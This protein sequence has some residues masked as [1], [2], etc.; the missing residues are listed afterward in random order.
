MEETRTGLRKEA[1]P[2]IETGRSEDATETAL[3]Q[4]FRRTD[5]S[6]WVAGPRRRARQDGGGV[7]EGSDEE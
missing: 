3:S 1:E 6:Q 5:E 4:I 7:T 2:R